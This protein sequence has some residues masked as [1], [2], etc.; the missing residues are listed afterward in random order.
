MQ[1]AH[2]RSIISV[3]Q[4]VGDGPYVSEAEARLRKRERKWVITWLLEELVHDLEHEHGHVL[5]RRLA[6]LRVV[7]EH[8]S[9]ILPTQTFDPFRI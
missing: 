5:G 4:R 2:V 3:V 6:Q 7:L 1:N 8:V 9:K